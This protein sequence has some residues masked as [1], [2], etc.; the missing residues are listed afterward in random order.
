VT[1]NEPVAGLSEGTFY[2]WRARIVGADPLFPRSPWR[3]IPGNTVTETKLRTS[4]CVDFDG[5]GRGVLGDPSCSSPVA[6]CNDD[7]PTSWATPGTTKNLRIVAQTA[8]V[9][10]PPADPGGTSLATRYDALRSGL[11][12]DFSAGE[13][14]E[15][16]DG[17]NTIA[18]DID[19][20]APG[21]V[22]HYLTRA[23]NGCP[24]GLGS[25]GA[26]SSGVEHEGPECP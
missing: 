7:D 21:G 10:D 16:N 8:L 4:G 26:G 24:A 20:P 11:A 1:L 14:I 13:C 9:W 2:H 19:E 23:R 25:L 3:S 12:S 22:F 5:D 17:P 15:S 6:D 18:I